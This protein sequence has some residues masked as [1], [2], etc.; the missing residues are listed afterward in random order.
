MINEGPAFV[1]IFMSHLER[2]FLRTCPADFK[3]TLYRRYIDDTFVL[4]REKE[5]AKNF[6]NFINKRHNNIEFTMECE[7]DDFLCFLDV[8][9]SRVDGGYTTNVY[10]KKTHSGQ[11]LNIY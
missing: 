4:F 1:N 10:R 11:G 6:L 3:P 8:K 7:K 2:E 9:V 5:Q